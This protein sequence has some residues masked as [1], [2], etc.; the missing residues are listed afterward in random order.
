MALC[1]P[2]LFFFFNLNFSIFVGLDT[3]KQIGPGDPKDHWAKRV[4]STDFGLFISIS[5][6]LILR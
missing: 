6:F 1:C 4:F 5:V 3:Q 2:F